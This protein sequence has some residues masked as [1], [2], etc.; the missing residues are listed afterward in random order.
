MKPEGADR[1][2]AKRRDRSAIAKGT[3]KPSGSVLPAA[4]RDASFAQSC[5]LLQTLHWLGPCRKDVCKLLRPFVSRTPA[6]SPHSACASSGDGR[7]RP[8]CRFQPSPTL[9]SFGEGPD[10]SPTRCKLAIASAAAPS[11]PLASRFPHLPRQAPA[12]PLATSR[13]FQRSGRGLMV[14]A[15]APASEA[16][17]AAAAAA[18]APAPAPPAPDT[19]DIE[20]LQPQP[21]TN[22][23]G[24]VWTRNWYPVV[25]GR[26]AACCQGEAE[27]ALPVHAPL[28]L[29]CQRP[30]SV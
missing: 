3:S 17:A 11:P 7:R 21:A 24:F 19:F 4:D 18:P 12:I 5:C 8:R 15:E 13:H 1:L 27:P 22:G 26:C 29:P 9:G 2:L 23:K 30:C 25:R 14:R 28:R 16:V 10:H 6:A 20:D